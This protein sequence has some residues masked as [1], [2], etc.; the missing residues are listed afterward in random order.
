[1]F[2]WITANKEWLLKQILKELGQKQEQ[3]VQLA[4][5]WWMNDFE[6]GNLAAFLQKIICNT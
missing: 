4:Q 3:F 6:G 2:R 5:L 1:M